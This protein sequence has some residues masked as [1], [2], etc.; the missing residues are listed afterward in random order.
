M[1]FQ[2]N[3]GVGSSSIRPFVAELCQVESRMK[4]VIQGHL[5]TLDLGAKNQ[6]KQQDC[7]NLAPTGVYGQR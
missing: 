5:L 7:M 1:E 4:N 2:D 6:T 3:N